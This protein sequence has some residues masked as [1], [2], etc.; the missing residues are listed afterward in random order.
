MKADQGIILPE[1]KPQ[2]TD[3]LGRLNRILFA[4]DTMEEA[5]LKKEM[6]EYGV[7]ERMLDQYFKKL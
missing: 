5:S 4:M 6:R 3:R 1:E 7:T 2:G